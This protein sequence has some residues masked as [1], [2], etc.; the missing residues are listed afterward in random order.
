MAF[1]FG[2][3]S[4]GFSGFRDL[5]LSV[6][7]STRAAIVG[8]NG[9]G[10]STLL[11]LIVG[12]IEPQQGEVT[13]GRRLVLGYYDQHF[14][15]LRQCAPKASVIVVPPFSLVFKVCIRKE[16]IRGSGLMSA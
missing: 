11:K 7:A 9:S 15:E 4:T 6:D 10:K 8:A 13:R 14:S 3:T 12:E 2:A 1:S 16:F 5:D